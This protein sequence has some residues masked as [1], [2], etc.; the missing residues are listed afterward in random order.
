MSGREE[1][2]DTTYLIPG[3]IGRL[4]GGALP[5]VL[6]SQ[7]TLNDTLFARVGAI[8]FRM[9]TR[10]VKLMSCEIIYISQ[11]R[12]IILLGAKSKNLLRRSQKK[13]QFAFTTQTSQTS[14]STLLV[15]ISS[16]I[17]PPS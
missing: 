11:K 13:N 5:L 16:Q 14:S 12:L 6:T 4:L 7:D 15:Q 10:N 9:V 3:S 8:C 2:I 1:T 17:P